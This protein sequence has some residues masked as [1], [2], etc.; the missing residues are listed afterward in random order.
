MQFSGKLARGAH[1][2]Y[3]YVYCRASGPSWSNPSMSF[4]ICFY[5]SAKNQAPVVMLAVTGRRLWIQLDLEEVAVASSARAVVGA[6]VTASVAGVAAVAATGAE[7][8]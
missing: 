5:R 2:N 3:E 6:E 1:E 4:A 7:S 8:T